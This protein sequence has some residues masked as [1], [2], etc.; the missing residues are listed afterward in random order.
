MLAKEPILADLPQEIRQVLRPYLDEVTGLFGAN[1]VAVI[2]YGSAARGEY[3]PGRSNLNLLLILVAHELDTLRR[4]S[5]L[6]RRWAR[7]N[8]VVPLFM[9][10]SEI[11]AAQ[12]LFP[13]EFLEIKEQHVLLAGRDPFPELQIDAR[14]LANQ[15]AAELRS[16]LLRLRQR[17][18][19]GG[20]QPEAAQILLPLSFTAVLPCLR[21]LFRWLGVPLPR[22]TDALLNELKPGL[23]VDAAVFQEVWS[24]KRGL[25]SP[26]PLE[27][28]RLFQRYVDSLE[29][30]I[31]RVDELRAGRS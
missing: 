20:G 8:V 5:K 26:G 4:Y 15:C 1:L 16:N 22:R 12:D 24:L 2:L 28:P 30:L 17:L 7:E 19:E 6:H 14:Y 18:V 10:V 23:G 21:G 3:L 31:R 9:T 27:I 11:Q 25:I 13:L 29:E